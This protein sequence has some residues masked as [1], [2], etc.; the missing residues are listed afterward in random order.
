V[1]HTPP[2]VVMHASPGD[3]ARMAK[4]APTC[5]DD[6]LDESAQTVHPDDVIDWSE[7]HVIVPPASTTIP[8][9]PCVPEYATPFTVKWSQQD[10]VENPYGVVST[11]AVRT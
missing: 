4:T 9:G 11:I 6:G 7:L 1:K 2:D 10:S 3:A 5:G 8:A